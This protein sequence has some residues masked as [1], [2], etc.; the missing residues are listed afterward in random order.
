MNTFWKCE[1]CWADNQA[2]ATQCSY[3]GK[4]LEESRKRNLAN[5]QSETRR[6]K[7][8]AVIK[9]S[10]LLV[11]VIALPI[12]GYTAWRWHKRLSKAATVDYQDRLKNDQLLDSEGKKAECEI[13]SELR[14]RSS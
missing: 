10:F 12:I 14:T 8:A 2:H 6:E 11:L 3:C 7:T 9:V 5:A 4:S 13:T 1:Y